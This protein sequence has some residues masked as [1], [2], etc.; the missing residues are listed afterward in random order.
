M[1]LMLGIIDIVS[2]MKIGVCK[3]SDESSQSFM[4]TPGR[5]VR[6]FCLKDVEVGNRDCLEGEIQ[7]KFYAVKQKK[8]LRFRK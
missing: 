6:N 7:G 2:G 8:E 4:N 5:G 3:F 1:V